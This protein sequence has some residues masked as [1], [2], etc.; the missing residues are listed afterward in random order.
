MQK[1]AK[2]LLHINHS[3]ANAESVQLKDSKYQAWKQ[4][5]READFTITEMAKMLYFSFLR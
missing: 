2:S 1:T 5:Y 3:M 4:Y